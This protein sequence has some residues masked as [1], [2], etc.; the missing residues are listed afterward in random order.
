MRGTGS[1]LWVQLWSEESGWGPPGW[2]SSVPSGAAHVSWFIPSCGACTMLLSPWLSITFISPSA[3]HPQLLFP[4]ITIHVEE[5]GVAPCKLLL[6][7]PS[8]LS[9]LG[10]D[11]PSEVVDLY[12][13]LVCKRLY[14]WFPNLNGSTYCYQKHAF[15]Q[16]GCISFIVFQSFWTVLVCVTLQRTFYRDKFDWEVSL[17]T[18]ENQIALPHAQKAG[19]QLWGCDWELEQ[20]GCP[21]AR[22]TRS[23]HNC[24]AYRLRPAW[25]DT[26]SHVECHTPPTG[27][28]FFNSER[29]III[30]AFHGLISIDVTGGV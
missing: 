24:R 20:I 2:H 10:P 29:D 13:I 14:I 12:H 25:E 3:L 5:L 7:V 23:T 19:A 6:C 21:H 8:H 16:S 1:A 18:T 15:I 17:M 27:A 30:N 4:M 9:T 11:I 22:W 28:S 26:R